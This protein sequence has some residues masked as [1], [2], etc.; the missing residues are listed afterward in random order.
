MDNKT[1]P[2]GNMDRHTILSNYIWRFLERWGAQGVTFV[3]SIV[4]ARLLDPDVYGIIALVTVFTI[5]LNIFLDSGF[6]NA[7]IQK[8][9]ADDLDF[10]SVFFFNITASVVLYAAIFFAAPLIA[11]FYDMPELTL[12]VRVMGTFLLISGVKNIQQAYVSRHMLF[13]KFFFATLGGTIG[14]AV[15]GIALAYYGFGVWALVA[16][17]LFN[18]LLDTIIL[19]IIVPWRPKRMFSMV[20]LRSLFSFAWKLLVSDLVYNG[21]TE[22]RQLLIGK[23]YTPADLAFYN[24]GYKFPHLISANINTSIN[25]ILFPAMSSVQD[26]VERVRNMLKKS[27]QLSQYVVAPMV[28]GLAVCGEPLIRIVLTEKWLPCVPYMQLFCLSM[29]FGHMGNANQNAIIALGRSD[30]KL[31]IEIIKTVVDIA[32]LLGTVFISPMAVCIGFVCGALIRIAICAW[33]NKKLLGYSFWRQMLDIL[34]NLIVTAVMAGIVWSVTLLHLSSWVTLLIQVPLGVVI[35]VG[36]SV[37]TKSE[38]FY[39]ILDLVKSYFTRKRKGNEENH[40]DQL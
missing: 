5:I 27:I 16:Q 23:F 6:G 18:A 10:S 14:A 7:L 2:P 1:T 25:S 17:Y 21:Y 24:Q 32:I 28:I 36:L 9:D 3:V 11:H 30:I 13:K 40:E 35:Y 29:A 34:P 15:I 8:K 38:P 22:L 19:W 26:D 37:L 33:P 31:R 20:R 12:V 39:Y 4:L